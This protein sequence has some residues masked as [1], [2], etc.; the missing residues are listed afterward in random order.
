MVPNFHVE[1]SE[2]LPLGEVPGLL[3]ESGFACL[4]LE[5]GLM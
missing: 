4:F 2:S 5:T 3:L 1:F